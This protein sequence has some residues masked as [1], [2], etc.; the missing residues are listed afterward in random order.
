MTAGRRGQG[1]RAARTIDQDV[2]VHDLAP[3]RF[4]GRDHRQ[5]RATGR[6]DVVNEDHPLA[7]LD[8]EAASELTPDDAVV[9]ADLLREDRPDP[10]LSAGLEGQDDAAGGR[11]GDQ[12]DGRRPIVAAMRS[13]P[14]AAQLARCD[15]VLEDLELLEIG[16]RVAT[17]LELEVTVAQGAR[18]AEQQLGALGDRRPGGGL[19]GGSDG[20]HRGTV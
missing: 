16:A 15:R 5:E 13:G 18:S 1:G 9:T 3:G 6:Q 20:G 7:A 12:S 17:A 14:E 19:E 8:G 11:T 4:D 10:Q 2:T